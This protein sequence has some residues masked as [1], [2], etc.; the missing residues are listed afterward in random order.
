MSQYSLLLD[1]ETPTAIILLLLIDKYGT[2]VLNWEASVIIDAVKELTHAKKLKERIANKV[3]SSVS[4]VNSNAYYIYPQV[5][6][7]TVT[8]VNGTNIYSDVFELSKPKE[9]AWFNTELL[10][11]DPPKSEEQFISRF[12]DSVRSFIG[13]VLD[14]FGV[15]K[16]PDILGMAYRKQRPQSNEDPDPSISR[17]IFK[18]QMDS[19]DEI[20]EYVGERLRHLFSLLK[21]LSLISVD[22]KQMEQSLNKVLGGKWLRTLKDT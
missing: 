4:V 13:S 19:T 17:G 6:N 12:N 20:N 9:M 10:L 7:E 11:L 8:A 5:Y 22:S 18:L 1:P 15:Y 2:D 21:N 14:Y 16:A 3:L